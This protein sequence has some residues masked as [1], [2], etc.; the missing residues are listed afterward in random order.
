MSKEIKTWIKQYETVLS[1]KEIELL[2]RATETI[3]KKC[4]GWRITVVSV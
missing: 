2:S 3:E 1:D 4:M